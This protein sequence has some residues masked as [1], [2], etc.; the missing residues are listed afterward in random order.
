ME[1]CGA[2]KMLCVPWLDLL[3]W[4][5]VCC[6]SVMLSRFAGGLE[7][8]ALPWSLCSVLLCCSWVSRSPLLLLFVVSVLFCAFVSLSFGELVVVGGSRLWT[9]SRG[10]VVSGCCFGSS[11]QESEN[12]GKLE[13]RF[14]RPKLCKAEVSKTRKNREKDCRFSGL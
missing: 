1:L 3:L 9:A 13:R 10:A 7:L 12:F 2:K 14:F 6:G 4:Y 8:A 11:C 5:M